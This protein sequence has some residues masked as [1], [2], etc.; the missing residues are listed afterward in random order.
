MAWLSQLGQ[1]IERLFNLDQNPLASDESIC[2]VAL[3]GRGVPSINKYLGSMVDGDPYSHVCITTVRHQ[4]QISRRKEDLIKTRVLVLDD[5]GTKVAPEDISTQPQYKVETS[6]GNEQWL[7]KIEPTDPMLYQRYAKLLVEDGLTCEGAALPGQLI[8]LPGSVKPS[9]PDFEARVTLS[10]NAP[11]YALKDLMKWLLNSPHAEVEMRLE[12]PK[13]YTPASAKET[14]DDG[15]FTHLVEKGLVV[16][17]GA[18]DWVTIECPWADQHSDGGP[19]AYYS[20]L[21]RGSDPGR[22]GFKCFHAHCKNKKTQHFS[23]WAV[24][25]GALIDNRP[26]RVTS[27]GDTEEVGYDGLRNYALKVGLEKEHLPDRIFTTGDKLATRQLPSRANVQHVMKAYGIEGQMNLMSRQS[28]LFMKPVANLA[29]VNTPEAMGP[30]VTRLLIDMMGYLGVQGE[31][32]LRTVIDEVAAEHSYHPMQEWL[33]NLEMWDGT[34]HIQDLASTFEMKEHAQELWPVFL[35]KWMVQ[36]VQAV[37]GWKDSQ[38]APY[39]LTFVGIQ[40]TGKGQWMRRFVPREFYSE[41]LHLDL[42]SYSSG[43]DSTM[44]ATGTPIVELGELDSTF[45]AARIGALKAYLARRDDVYRMPYARTSVTVPRTT[46]YLAS[47]NSTN[48]LSDPTG[49]R[50][51]WPVHVDSCD[52]THDL[53]CSKAWSQAY[54]MWQ[55]GA[56]YWLNPEE[57]E[58][59]ELLVNIHSQRVDADDA[60]DEFISDH[61]PGSHSVCVP[62]T[63]RSVCRHIGISPHPANTNLVADRLTEAYGIK[64]KIRDPNTPGRY[65]KNAWPIPWPDIDVNMGRTGTV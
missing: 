65:V 6:P 25:H 5:V 29:D 15:I 24:E 50:R 41:G 38:G 1:S 12:E 28:E 9:R 61:A 33:N 59:H 23:Q 49:S 56:I 44:V 51:F 19:Y 64:R 11:P 35:R 47:V 20:P 37:C 13:S 26:A 21:G 60:I 42:S 55:S 3:D 22:R 36:V 32:T 30:H 54:A 10:L 7:Y 58:K 18:S 2:V 63:V 57:E 45:G 16:G 40:G 27:E 8:R 31:S 4:H 52:Y 43:R 39:V 34:D 62:M 48:F 53:D 14:E 46:A 17:A